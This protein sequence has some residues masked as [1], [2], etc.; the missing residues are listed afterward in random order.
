MKFPTSRLAVAIGAPRG[1]SLVATLALMMLLVVVALGMLSL[2]SVSLRTTGREATYQQARHHARLAIQMALGELQVLAGPDQRVTAPASIGRGDDAPRRHLTGVWE[3]WKWNGLGST[4]DWEAEKR[5]RF[6][7]W[8]ASANSHGANRLPEFADATPTGDHVRLVGPSASG[9]DAVEGELVPLRGPNRQAR[10]KYAWVAFDESQKISV[11]L[12]PDPEKETF[13]SSYNR[14]GAAYE[15][16]FQSVRDFNWSLL[17]ERREERPKLTTV[18]QARLLGI[19]K[20][21]LP[22]HDLTSGSKGLLTNV[23]T[24][25]FANDLSTL[26]DSATLP[27][28]WRQRFIYSDT[29]TPMVP[30]PTRFAGAN[31]LPSPDPTW[32]LLHSHYRSFSRVTPGSVPRFEVSANSLAARPNTNVSGSALHHHP[33]FTQQQVAPVIAKAQFVF[34]LGFA[35]GGTLETMWKNG[36]ARYSPASLR[37]K[38]MTWLVIDPV[39]TLWNPYNVP[40]SFSALRIDLY[41][42]PFAFRIYKNGT[43]ISGDHTPLTNAHTV[44]N[45]VDRQNRFYKL[46]LLPEKGH[47]TRLLQP[48]EHL[49]FTAHEHIMHGGHEY[50]LNGVTLRPGFNPPA[51]ANSNSDVGGI[52]TMNLFV[53]AAGVSNGKDY[54]KAVRTVGVKTGDRIQVDVTAKH[55]GA[56]SVAESNGKE[57]TGLLKY[58]VGE[59]DDAKLIGGIE[60]DY[61]TREKQLLPNLAKEDLPTL[62]VPAGIPEN[63]QGDG[64]LKPPPAVRYKEPFLI[65]TFQQKTERDSLFPARGWL[66]N[67]PSNLYAS[68][69]LD[70]TEDFE[71]HG[72]EMRWEPM[73]DWPPDSPSIELSVE[74]NRGYGGPGIYS[75]SGSEF[76]T[77][78]SLPLAPAQ[79]LG[80]LRHAPLNPGGQLPLTAQVVGNSFR[81][82]L[83]EPNRVRKEMG[84]RSYLDHSYLANNALFDSWFLSTAA[85]SPAVGGFEARNAK[86]LLKGLLLNAEKLPNARFLSEARNQGGDPWVDELLADPEGFRKLAAYLAIDGAF[87]INSTRVAAWQA[88]LASSTG[89]SVPLADFSTQEEKQLAVVRNLLTVDGSGGPESDVGKWNGF[90][91]LDKDQIGRLATAIV[92]QVKQ[93]G[94]F[95]SLA[96]FVNRRP[97]DDDFAQCGAVEAAIESTYLNQEVLDENH[98]IGSG[99]ANTADGATTV[100]NQADLLTP[101]FPQLTA[102]GDTFRI[103]ACGQATG[104]N[105]EIIR[106]WCEATV[107]RTAAYVD[108]ADPATAPPH[109]PVNQTFGR[110]FEIVSFR[111]LTLDEL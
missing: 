109:S 29:D 32:T 65:A 77:F 70:Q 66:N 79:S 6:K 58:Y 35:Y 97:G 27:P 94:P 86:S 10:G 84:D 73:T 18:G 108:P 82:P 9:D 38:Y 95:L 11:S 24:G 54:G 64:N 22:F 91:V 111:W 12:P 41:R 47:S 49:V 102:R 105:G 28:A 3:G 1:F 31:P 14:L 63:I 33:A 46:R 51:G 85:T 103:R 57:I 8:L 93:R 104:V 43:L 110:R 100:I 87:N 101:L 83:L 78:A 26:F 15:P 17:T 42:I 52:T 67:N 21:N 36:S 92:D 81:P 98:R 55:S 59:G 34:S 20:E 53:N 39:I 16:G 56:D 19:E 75:Q 37:D 23:A 25:G 61:G 80:Q 107:Q 4:P 50:N 48:G 96:E 88:L 74:G 7:G 45:F 40:I 89:G 68:A 90:R 76:A 13:A 60:L 71:H 106:V 5:Q 72:Y 44:N 62:V 2:A 69:G 99:S 30:P